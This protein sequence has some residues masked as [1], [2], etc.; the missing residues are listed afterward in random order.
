MHEAVKFLI[1][2]RV[3]NPISQLSPWGLTKPH[4]G[5]LTLLTIIPWDQ[6][7]HMAHPNFTCLPNPA[8]GEPKI[9][10]GGSP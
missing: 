1:I 3:T 4:Q 9:C 5:N 8:H 7:S 10:I 2:V 6:Q